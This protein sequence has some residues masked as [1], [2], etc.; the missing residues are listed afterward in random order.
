MIDHESSRHTSDK[1]V[2]ALEDEE[3]EIV[4]KSW[5][6][7]SQVVVNSIDFLHNFNGKMIFVTTWVLKPCQLFQTISR[8]RSSIV[9]IS[10]SGESSSVPLSRNGRINWF[11]HRFVTLITNI[12]IIWIYPDHNKTTDHC[13]WHCRVFSEYQ[14]PLLLPLE[15]SVS[16]F[17]GGYTQSAV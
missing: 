13:I 6:N 14:I 8:K 15:S 4:W 11:R 9:S 3:L 10:F 2:S 1:F 5:H 7:L 12:A 17:G 16:H